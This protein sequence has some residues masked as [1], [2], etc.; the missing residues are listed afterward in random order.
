MKNALAIDLE[1]WHQIVQWKIAGVIPPSSKSLFDQMDYL[2]A[3]LDQHQT[4]ATFFTLGIV[5]Q[6]NP[7]L[8]RRIAA[9]GHEIA[10][11]G[12]AHH[13]IYN[14]SPELFREDARR[15]KLLL[16]D[17]TGSPIAGYRAAEFSIV[18]RTLWALEV[19][20]ELGYSYDSS[21]FPIRHRRYG[22]PDFDP[23]IYDYQLKNGHHLI[24][25][26]L[27]IYQ[28]R[29]IRLPLA[30]GG[31]FRL[32][33]LELINRAVAQ[34]NKAKIPLITYFHPYEFN[35][36]RLKSFDF[37]QPSSLREKIKGWRCDFLQNLGR[38]SVSA[39]LEALL[40]NFSFTSCRK[41]IDNIT[42]PKGTITF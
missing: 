26:P 4:K 10:S 35:Q 18:R 20:A 7:Q 19:L 23:G 8:I 5:A 24:E 32:I 42:I 21:I 34:L 15:S 30:G 14:I 36:T 2:L 39:K 6:E 28:W 16:E 38:K 9:L 22:I 25:M 40:R 29:K 3:L 11:H 17:I 37:F 41:L 13:C 1:D 12:Y 27:S 33:P 31:Y